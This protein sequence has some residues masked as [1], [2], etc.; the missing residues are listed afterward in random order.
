MPPYNGSK[1]YCLK[2]INSYGEIVV[3]AVCGIA[4]QRRSGKNAVYHRFQSD[5]NGTWHWNGST[6]EKYALVHLEDKAQRYHVDVRNGSNTFN[7]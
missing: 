4:G 2:I 6:I 3:V 7:R 5:G 1:I